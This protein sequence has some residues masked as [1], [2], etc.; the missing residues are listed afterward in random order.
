MLGRVQHKDEWTHAHSLWS[1]RIW[2]PFSSVWREN[3]FFQQVSEGMFNSTDPMHIV[4][5]HNIPERWLLGLPFQVTSQVW[6]FYFHSGARLSKG[7]RVIRFLRTWLLRYKVVTYQFLIN[8]QFKASLT[9]E[10]QI[11]HQCLHLNHCL[12]IKLHQLALYLRLFT[13]LGVSLLTKERS[14]Y[15]QVPFALGTIR[16]MSKDSH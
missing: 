11:S 14:S 9:H 13:I 5:S 8:I 1:I 4:I 15:Y 3:G 7:S 12:I 6:S 2:S 16:V 10:C